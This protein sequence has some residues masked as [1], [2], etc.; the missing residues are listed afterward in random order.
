MVKV[1]LYIMTVPFSVW[2]LESLRL[3][4]LFKKN[5][6]LQIKVFYLLL[7]LALSYL[8]VNCLYDFSY[9]FQSLK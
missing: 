2:C 3:D 4:T 8:V 1:L 9:Y 7:S 6:F 5:R